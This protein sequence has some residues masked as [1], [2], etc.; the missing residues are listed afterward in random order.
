[1]HQKCRQK[2]L[3]KKKIIKK[4]SSKEG[5]KVAVKKICQK[6][7]VKKNSKIRQKIVKNIL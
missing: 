3:S 4:I 7:I 6:K 5:Q 2:N 1:M